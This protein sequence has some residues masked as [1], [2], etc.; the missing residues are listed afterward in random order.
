MGATRR[1][2]S[3]LKA[4]NPTLKKHL[5]CAPSKQDTCC[6]HSLP[7]S[8]TFSI[9]HEGMAQPLRTVTS[10]VHPNP[11]PGW[12]RPKWQPQNIHKINLFQLIFLFRLSEA[13]HL[14]VLG[15]SSQLSFCQM[16]HPLPWSSSGPVS[17]VPSLYRH[18]YL[19]QPIL[20]LG[21]IQVQN[22]YLE[23]LPI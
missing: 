22:N 20:A 18:T 11:L 23:F 10:Q 9:T 14:P 2:T 3:H 19:S 21:S 13:I 8:P 12:Q 7:I 4:Y 16:E 17:D 6:S 15:L 1:P 5:L